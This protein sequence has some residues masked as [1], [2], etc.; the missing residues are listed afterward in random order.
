VDCGGTC[1]AC[2]SC[3][4]PSNLTISNVEKNRVTLN[5]DTV[6]N[7]ILYRVNIRVLGVEDWY[8]FQTQTNSITIRGL[9][10]ETVYEWRV[11]TDCERKDSDWSPICSF[12]SSDPNSGVCEEPPVTPTCEDGIQNGDETGVDC[13]GSCTA[14]QQEET[15]TCEDGIQNGDE[16]GIDCGGSCAACEQE[17]TPTCEDGVQNGDETGVDCGGSCAACPTCDDGILNGDEEEVDCGGTCVP[18]S[19]CKAPDGLFV[20]NF[21]RGRVTLNWNPVDGAERYTIEIRLEGSTTWYEFRT[22]NTSQIIRG[23]SRGAN[24]EWRLASSCSEETSNWSAICTFN[25][26]D[27]TTGQCSTPDVPTC[28]D[29]IQN[30]DET[31]I[32]CGGSCAACEQEETPTCEDGIQNG[33]ETGIDCGG[34]CAACE[35]EE[36]PTCEDGI[37]NGDETGIDCGGSC[38]ACEQEQTPTCEDGIQNGDETG[39]DCGGSCAP[40]EE[41]SCPVPTDLLQRAL[42]TNAILS[43][44]G[45]GEADSYRVQYRIRETTEWS[46][47]IISRDQVLIARLTRGSTYEWRVQTICSESTSEWSISA[48]FVAGAS[49]NVSGRMGAARATTAVDVQIQPNP[50]RDILFVTLPDLSAGQTQVRLLDLNGKVWI[51]QSMEAGAGTLQLDL[52]ILPKGLYFVRV[53]NEGTV[54]LKRVVVQ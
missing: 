10:R 17:E 46:E 24:Y 54:H 50:A 5:W 16:T 44:Q 7:V 19:S 34:S 15:P 26:D 28:E 25:S 41:A 6:E 13:G 49:G 40:C 48:F 32:D 45:S 22:S 53:E 21:A 1:V 52:S 36:T 39:I 14:C 9:A 20:D 11:L 38:T 27:P 29:G 43:W 30:G 12:N 37:Q 51:S 8:S 47:R 2:P 3:N 35:Q 42:G 18:C 23:L 33:D 31:G 4:I